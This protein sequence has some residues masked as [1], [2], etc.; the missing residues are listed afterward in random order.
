MAIGSSH[1]A[2]TDERP[3]KTVAAPL[4]L[5]NAVS[6]ATSKNTQTHSEASP[7][8]RESTIFER[9]D[10]ASQGKV[11]KKMASRRTLMMWRLR[12]SQNGIIENETYKKGGT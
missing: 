12:I 1:P 9:I 5:A 6:R 3:V 10:E 8:G 7:S 11:N 4:G 2:P